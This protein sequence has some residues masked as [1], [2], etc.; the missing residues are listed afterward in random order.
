V[1]WRPVLWARASAGWG[2]YLSTEVPR[3][4]AQA[5]CLV[6]P[7]IHDGWGAVA[8]ESLMVGT[9]VV[10]SDACGVAGVVQASGVGG[11]FP[12][13]DKDVAWST[14][15]LPNCLAGCCATRCAAPDCRVGHLPWRGSWGA[16]LAR[17][18]DAYKDNMM[19][20]V[21][22]PVA[23]V[24]EGGTLMCGL[25]IAVA[26]KPIGCGE[27]QLF[28]GQLWNH[29]HRR[30]PDAEGI[31]QDSGV[32][33]GHR[34]LAIQDLDVRSNQPLALCLWSIRHRL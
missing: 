29:M 28:V 26:A 20:M 27:L 33:L 24:A 7:S 1:L 3:A 15:L 8:S 21:P 16:I 9:P 10:C 17:N 25:L 5:D 32:W 11:V 19:V 23:P 30:G 13:K 6:L 2:S 4:M 31:W 18:I 12:V 22:R 14:C 34:R